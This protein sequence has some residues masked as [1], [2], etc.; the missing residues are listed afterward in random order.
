MAELI[1]GFEQAVWVGPGPWL[2]YPL[3]NAALGEQVR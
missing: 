2:N 1:D 3:R